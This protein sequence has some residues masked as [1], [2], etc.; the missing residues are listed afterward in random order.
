M[1]VVDGAHGLAAAAA[2]GGARGLA[3]DGCVS[4]RVVY[5]VRSV[6]FGGGSFV[7][8]CSGDDVVLRGGGFLGSGGGSDV[9]HGAVLFS[10]VLI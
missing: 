1:G 2:G 10:C 7:G 6:A 4:G 8:G 3:S 9:P 5:G